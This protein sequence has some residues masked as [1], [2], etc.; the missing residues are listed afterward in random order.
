MRTRPLAVILSVVAITGCGSPEPRPPEP[1]PAAPQVAATASRPRADFARAMAQVK[2][3]MH[4][5][6]VTRL[7]GVPDDVQPDRNGSADTVEVWRWGT[8]A[9]GGLGTLGTVHVRADRTVS[10]VR[11]GDG[12]PPD[13][14]MFPEPEL[15]R[16][17]RIV[18]R[19][20]SYDAPHDPRRLIEAVNAL[21]A[22][23]RERALAVLREYLRVSSPL[24]D[25][26]R[27]GS[28]LVMRTLFDVPAE[29]GY[30]PVM[31]VGSSSPP[32][33]ADLRTVPRFP[34]VI[35]DD[36]P[37]RIT[38]CCVLGGHA[39]QPEAHLAYYE[40]AGVLRAAPLTPP[41]DPAATIQRIAG[42][43]DAA[44][45]V[46]HGLD[47]PSGQALILRQGLL[48]VPRD[49]A[50]ENEPLRCTDDAGRALPLDACAPPIPR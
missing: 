18:D 26:G 9:P 25:P 43:P 30:L 19:V 38:T 46:A 36:V 48:M 23:G 1:R 3:G 37:L 12:V 27:G 8:D 7:I 44:W 13:R 34:I 17:L 21:Q 39:Q 28:F 47:N 11:G 24:D 22:L 45:L 4:V 49:P 6:Q 2:D 50:L 14:A 32:E 5:D 40:E 29:P 15:Q 10:W 35:V 16:L 33:P 41:A 31:M 20:P 42:A